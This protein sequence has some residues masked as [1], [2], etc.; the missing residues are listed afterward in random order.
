MDDIQY[1]VMAGLLALYFSLRAAPH[2][3]WA[4]LGLSVYA[5]A[6]LVAFVTGFVLLQVRD[7][8]LFWLA[9]PLLKDVIAIYFRGANFDITKL[10]KDGTL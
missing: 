4:S 8:I 5:G 6:S 10:K 1:I 2:N 3:K 7:I 9:L